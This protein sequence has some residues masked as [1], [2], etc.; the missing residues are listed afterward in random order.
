MLTILYN[1]MATK[2]KSAKVKIVG[3]LNFDGL[4]IALKSAKSSLLPM[5][6]PSKF[7]PSPILFCCFIPL[8]NPL[9]YCTDFRQPSHSDIPSVLDLSIDFSIIVF[10]YPSLVDM[11]PPKEVVNIFLL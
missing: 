7:K 9:F 2:K 8:F 3:R 1:Q 4:V 5:I 11:L 10:E 6:C